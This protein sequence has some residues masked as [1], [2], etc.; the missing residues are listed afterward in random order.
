MLVL[1]EL[2]VLGQITPAST[3]EKATMYSTARQPFWICQS[4]SETYSRMFG[5][6]NVAHSND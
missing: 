5:C 6:R 4:V 2:I 1:R 3:P